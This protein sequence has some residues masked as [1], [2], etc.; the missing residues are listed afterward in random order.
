MPSSVVATLIADRDQLRLRDVHTKCAAQGATGFE[1]WR[2]LNEGVAADF[3]SA[4]LTT[5]RAALDEARELFC[6]LAHEGGLVAEP[7]GGTT[8][9]AWARQPLAGFKLA[10]MEGGTA[11]FDEARP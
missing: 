8:A 5:I 11:V 6:A 3:F 1:S 2:W 4:P 9:G 10:E 7:M